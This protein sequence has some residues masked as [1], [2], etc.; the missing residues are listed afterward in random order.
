MIDSPFPAATWTGDRFDGREN[1]LAAHPGAL[2]ARLL[3]NLEDARVLAVHPG[4]DA[5]STPAH[6]RADDHGSVCLM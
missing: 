4:A 5:R 3:V 1:A 2:P 6:S